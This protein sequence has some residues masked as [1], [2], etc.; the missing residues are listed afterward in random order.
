MQHLKECCHIKGILCH[1][2]LIAESVNDGS[3]DGLSQLY[4]LRAIVECG[5]MRI[6]DRLY[7]S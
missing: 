1:V 7:A 6:G 5:G 4:V 2:V 3:V